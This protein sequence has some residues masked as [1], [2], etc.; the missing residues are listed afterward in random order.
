MFHVHFLST[1]S[2]II[3]SPWFAFFGGFFQPMHLMVIGII[4]VLLWGKSIPDIAF[5][6]GCRFVRFRRGMLDLVQIVAKSWER[7]RRWLRGR[8]HDEPGGSLAR[9]EPPDK[10]RPPAQVALVPPKYSED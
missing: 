3:L 4:A 1:D 2:L 9:L 5:W 8:N 6:L 10:P 7:I